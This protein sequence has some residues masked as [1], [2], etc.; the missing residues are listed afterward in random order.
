M[1]RPK[2]VM[3]NSV[4]LDGSFIGFSVDLGLHYSL[5]REYSKFMTL[6]GSQ[7]VVPGVREYS[8][9][10]PPA[11]EQSDFIKPDKAP[12]IPY[13]VVVDSGGITR[14]LLHLLRRADYFRDVIVLTSKKAGWEFIDYLEKRH[15]D[16]FVCGEE[17]VDLIKALDSL[18]EK[19][20]VETMMVDAGPTLNRV[21]LEQR[22]LDEISL[23][24]HPVLVGGTSNKCL[25]QLTESVKGIKLELLKSSQHGQGTVLLR[26]KVVYE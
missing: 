25:Y 17:K 12:G 24:V 16:Y 13:F 23:L 21:L 14:G 4:S 20:S 2:I 3:V 10:N 1:K 7:T 26:Y 11:E 6:S 19:Y 15:Y 8:E 18:V 5:N 22:L 9:G